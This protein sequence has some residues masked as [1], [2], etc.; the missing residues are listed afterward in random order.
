[1]FRFL[2]LKRLL[3]KD[4]LYPGYL[5]GN[6][7][8]RHFV[9]SMYMNKLRNFSIIRSRKKTSNNQFDSE[10]KLLRSYREGIP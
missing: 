10:N 1:M 7:E 4:Q 8:G 2:L 9:L 6:I 3:Q 5:R